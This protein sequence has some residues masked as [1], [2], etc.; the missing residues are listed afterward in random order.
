MAR[1]FHINSKTVVAP[2]AAFTMA[3]LLYVYTRSSIRAAKRNA[4]RTRSAD[5]GQI[6]WRN[7][8]LRRHGVLERPGEQ[9]TFK[10]LVTGAKSKVE[11]NVGKGNQRSEEEERLRARKAR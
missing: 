2:I 9:D 1:N 7:E 11:K 10:E 8:S 4:E 6:S 5:G 3:G